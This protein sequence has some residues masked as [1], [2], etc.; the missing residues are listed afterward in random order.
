[1]L[2]VMTAGTRHAPEWVVA[3]RRSYSLRAMVW[4]WMDLLF[5]T[6]PTLPFLIRSWRGKGTLSLALRLEIVLGLIVLVFLWIAVKGWTRP[7][8]YRRAADLLTG[9][10]VRYE[11]A[12]D[13]AEAVLERADLAAAKILQGPL[14]PVRV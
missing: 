11:V 9:A 10:I 8:R 6:L 5:R 1:M 13:A 4:Q 2:L 12:G 7:R 14:P 3:K